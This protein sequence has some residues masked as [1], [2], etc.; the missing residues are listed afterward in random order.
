MNK[1]SYYFLLTFV[2]ILNKSLG[3]EL[4]LLHSEPVVELEA[5]QT[6]EGSFLTATMERTDTGDKV[7]LYRSTDLGYHWIVSDSIVS[8]DNG[9]LSAFDPVLAQDEMGRIYLIVMR[10]VSEGDDVINID[11]ELYASIDDGVNW[12]YI[13]DPHS[14]LG[15][16]D[17]PQLIAKEDGELHLVY[18]L[19][20]TIDGTFTGDAVYKKSLNGGISWSEPYVFLWDFSNSVGPDLNWYMDDQ[21]IMGYGSSTDPELFVTIGSQTDVDWSELRVLPSSES[22]NIVKPITNPDESI[23]Y[24]IS[25]KPHE[26]EAMINFHRYVHATDSWTILEIT[27]GAYAEAVL[28]DENAIH[29][30]YNKKIG[31]E[32]QLCYIYSVDNGLTFTEPVVLYK[33]LFETNYAGEYQSLILGEDGLLYLTFCDWSDLS[34]AKMLIFPTF[35]SET[36]VGIGAIKTI[37]YNLYPNPAS[38]NLLLTF[39][40]E[41]KPSN[42]RI[43][44]MN[45]KL[46]KQQNVIGEGQMHIDLSGFT[47]G[48]YLI[49]FHSANQIVIKQFKVIN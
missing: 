48:S 49:Q 26:T 20:R 34:K 17:Y 6:S 43:Y 40:L 47:A 27:T 33:G 1:L 10:Q 2:F 32:Y 35:I 11:L 42:I 46:I 37:D 25:H 23:V 45:G 24:L 30:I 14:G 12:D 21:L 4:G 39:S 41:N 28:D 13:G 3:Q 22:G 15:A 18:S 38:T 44:D 36:S 7:I 19:F 5:V 31:E 8:G 16:A 9:M 29:F